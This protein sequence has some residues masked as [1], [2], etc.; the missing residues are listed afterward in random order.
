[1][2]RPER[3]MVSERGEGRIDRPKKRAAEAA[4]SYKGNNSHNAGR[5]AE[6]ILN[7]PDRKP[8]ITVPND[9]EIHMVELD[10]DLS[11]RNY[12]PSYSFRRV[13]NR[14][15]CAVAVDNGPAH[16]QERIGALASLPAHGGRSVGTG[17]K[18]RCAGD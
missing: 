14:L 13:A 4:L 9:R 15:A 8:L 16:R 6:I 1:M 5:S 7:D 17:S 2:R 10:H 18:Q 3:G 11:R 12:R